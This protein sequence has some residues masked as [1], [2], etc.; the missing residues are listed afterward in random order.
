M[1]LQ[2]TTNWPA[3]HDEMGASSPPT[4]AAKPIAI[5]LALLGVAT[6]VIAMIATLPATLIARSFKLEPA[7]AVNGTVWS[8]DANLVG[9]DRVSWTADALGSL[10]S[11]S[12]QAD[13]SVTGELTQLNARMS[14]RGDAIVVSNLSGV[15]GWSLVTTVAPATGLDCDIGIRFAD[16]VVSVKN[17]VVSLS[18]R[19]SSS[20][21]TCLSTT[22]GKTFPAP[23][24]AAVATARGGASQIRITLASDPSALLANIETGASGEIK[25]TVQPRALKLIPGA[26]ASGSIV[27][28][29][30]S[31]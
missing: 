23:A 15:A 26:I 20:D 30:R 9:G 7:A 8:G 19:A 14:M 1:S 2:P 24:A 4:F 31:P 27:Y 13:L 25:A 6:F 18:G 12:V 11:L 21:G 17:S 22:D 16:A 29:M 10:S 5:G 28:E 3:S